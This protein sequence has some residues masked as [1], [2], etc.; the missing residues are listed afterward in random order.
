MPQDNISETKPKMKPSFGDLLFAVW[1]SIVHILDSLPKLGY[2]MGSQQRE[3]NDREIGE[4]A[5]YLCSKYIEARFNRSEL[6]L[7]KPKAKSNSKRPEIKFEATC[8][9]DVFDTLCEM[10]ELLEKSY[11]L[12]F[13]NV[14]GQL[15]FRLSL[16]LV[17]CDVFN[18]V[19]DQIIASGISWG[20]I[21]A[22]YAFAGALAL[23]CTKY[24]DARLV[25][26]VSKWMARFTTSRLCPWIRQN[27]GWVR[28]CKLFNIFKSLRA[29]HIYECKPVGYFRISTGMFR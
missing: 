7:Y 29:P 6:C 23:D 20:R 18:R 27:G 16:E 10:G 26:L 22:L 13:N 5:R 1:T 19:C 24:G 28:F 14:V 15:N 3:I 9:Q 25:K 17:V 12:L 11:P 8:S 2:I 21:V 4:Q